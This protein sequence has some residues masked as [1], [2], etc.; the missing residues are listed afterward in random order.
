MARK[1]EFMAS[2]GYSE[3]APEKACQSLSKL[4]YDAVGW[5]MA[6]CNPREHT[7]EQL[8]SLVDLPKKYNMEIGE[9]V[10]QQNVVCLEDSAQQDNIKLVIECIEMASEIGAPVINLF[11]GPPAWIEGTGKIGVDIKEGQA[12]DL[13]LGAY[14]QF[15][16][17]AEKHQV[18][19]AVEG[20]WAMLCHDYYTTKPLIDEFD[21]PWLGVNLDPSHDVLAGNLD[22]GW[23][24]KQWAKK[25]RIKHVHI[26]DAV[27]V[28]TDGLFIFP[29]L[30]E[31]NVDWKAFCTALDEVG[32]DGQM[33]VEY[34][35][36]VY[37]DTVLGGDTEEAARVSMAQ[38]KKIIW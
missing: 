37:H 15:V 26:K 7:K 27:G 17:A 11:T 13:V 30:G 12:W 32:Y 28:Q 3:M 20:V 2:L 22:V 5:T 25:D 9:L 1:I 33:S 21:S 38:L 4:G 24:V 19:L 8:R 23:I 16:K 6:H 35:S 31:G 10:V 18:L 36:F 29:M 14:E 34:E